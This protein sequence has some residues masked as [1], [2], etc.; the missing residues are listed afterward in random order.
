MSF[1][2]LVQFAQAEVDVV[3][4]R[5]QQRRATAFEGLK[6]GPARTSK[7]KTSK[8]LY[9]ESPGVSRYSSSLHEVHGDMLGDAM[10]YPAIQ[11]PRFR[12]QRCLLL[13]RP[14]KDRNFS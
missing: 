10:Q 9:A 7:P 4:A 8:L 2:E 3:R 11:I 12:Q 1:L 5:G 6:D 14:Q 13:A